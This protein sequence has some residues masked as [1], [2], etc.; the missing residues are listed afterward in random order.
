V[1]NSQNEPKDIV[2]FLE[3]LF[4]VPVVTNWVLGTG[5]WVLGTGYWV[6]GTGYWVPP[7]TFIVPK[8]SE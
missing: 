2:D 5:Y 1:Y 7:T 6:L 4:A 8:S 3:N